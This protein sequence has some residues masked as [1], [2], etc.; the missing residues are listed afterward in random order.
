M[1]AAAA[2]APRTVNNTDGVQRRVNNTDGVQRHVNNTGGVQRRVNNTDGVQRRVNNTE[3][4]TQAL[5]LGAHASHHSAAHETHPF[6]ACARSAALLLSALAL[7]PRGSRRRSRRLHARPARH[8]SPK[9]TRQ[10]LEKHCWCG[11]H[12][13]PMTSG[14][15]GQ[16]KQRAC[17]ALSRLRPHRSTF[18]GRWTGGTAAWTASPP[19][20]RRRQTCDTKDSGTAP[21]H[22]NNTHSNRPQG[23]RTCIH[24]EANARERAW[25]PERH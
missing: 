10:H 15:H 19:A 16:R 20:A 9:R 3:G 6:A 2:A 13:P 5:Q 8:V 18:R 4:G 17:H 23:L 24:R 7:R 22:A 12:T 25:S 14:T 11:S 1:R 21:Q